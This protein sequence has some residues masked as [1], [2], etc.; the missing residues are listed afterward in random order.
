MEA[1]TYEVNLNVMVKAMTNGL[2]KRCGPIIENLTECL[3]FLDM[4]TRHF[5]W[6]QK[7]GA[8]VLGH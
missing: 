8:A 6:A 2:S 4:N 7:R 1:Q 5:L 3:Q